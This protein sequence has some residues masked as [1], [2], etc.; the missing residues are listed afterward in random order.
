MSYPFFPHVRI[1]ASDFL[2]VHFSGEVVQ[3]VKERVSRV[4]SGGWVTSSELTKYVVRSRRISEVV[5]ECRALNPAIDRV[6]KK[7]SIIDITQTVR[8]AHTA[9]PSDLAHTSTLPHSSGDRIP[10]QTKLKRTRPNEVLRP[11][12]PAPPERAQAG[13]SGKASAGC[14]MP[15]APPPKPRTRL[16]A[17]RVT[18]PPAS[19]GHSNALSGGVMAARMP[20]ALASL[21]NSISFS[22]KQRLFHSLPLDYRLASF[23]PDGSLPLSPLLPRLLPSPSFTCHSSLSL[24]HPIRATLTRYLLHSTHSHSNSPSLIPHATRPSPPLPFFRHVPSPVFRYATSRPPSFITRTSLTLFQQTPLP[25]RSP[26]FTST[27]PLPFHTHL[28]PLFSSLPHPP[29]SFSLA[30]S[31]V[32]LLSARH[33]HLL[34]IPHSQLL[35]SSL[36]PPMRTPLFTPHSTPSKSHCPLP[37]YSSPTLHPRPVF[38]FPPSHSLFIPSPSHST[39][40]PSLSSPPSIPLPCPQNTHD[41]LMTHASGWHG[42]PPTTRQPHSPH[43]SVSR[44]VWWCDLTSY[45]PPPPLPPPVPPPASPSILTP[46]PSFL[47]P[48]P[49][50]PRVLSLPSPPPTLIF[51]HLPSLSFVP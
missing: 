49:P 18:P 36:P 34:L 23:T 35:S 11:A 21:L 22:P 8:H 14:G 42:L 32:S 48:F 29:R 1:L 13:P 30:A 19:K 43:A 16:G 3:G 28:P 7:T 50:S 51:F 27:S 24:S 12:S 9:P 38:H 39:P 45:S 10:P 37:L 47:P 15:R 26:S 20:C 40:T 17:V 25:L 33:S 46:P 2:F 6:V 31:L 41:S 4:S 5:V 44:D